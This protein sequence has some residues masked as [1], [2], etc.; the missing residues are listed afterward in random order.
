MTTDRDRQTDRHVSY[1][2]VVLAVQTSD[3]LHWLGAEGKKKLV[4]FFYFPVAYLILFYTIWLTSK[5]THTPD[6]Q[7]RTNHRRLFKIICFFYPRLH[8]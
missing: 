4:V 5:L 2:A 3:S 1:A 6:F 7:E 8:N